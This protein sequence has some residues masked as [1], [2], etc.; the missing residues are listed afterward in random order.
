MADLT[1]KTVVILGGAGLIGSAFSRACAQS[2][3]TVVIGDI[4]AKNGEKLAREISGSFLHIDISKPAAVENAA[5]EM[6]IKHGKID[7]VV[8][9]SYPKTKKF[10]T[11]FN[12]A[13]VNDMLAD[14][15]LQIGACLSTVKAFAP[16]MES[17]QTGSIVLLGSI[18]GAVA[19]R[20]DIYEGTSITTP[21]EYA[22]I[23]GS[24][25]ALVR[26]F[27]SLLGPS[28][29]RVN[30]ISPGGISDKQPQQFIDAYARYLKLG[31]GLL[32]PEDVVGAL[33]YL[34]SD[35]SK[36][37]TGQNLVIDGGWSL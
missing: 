16:L 3:A 10:G 34:F 26:Y 17:Q 19:P 18:Y 9:A 28:G 15:S 32:D 37:M 23:K 1:G 25:L 12:K 14:I 4:D 11:P 36:N 22:A 24:V 29:I 6:A 35:A 27:A 7:G 21:A 31:T 33:V 5:K 2:G 20:F 8:N 30:A 13:K